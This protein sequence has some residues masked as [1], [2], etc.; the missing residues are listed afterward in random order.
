MRRRAT[1]FIAL[2]L[3]A[4]SLSGCAHEQTAQGPYR[5]AYLAD[6]GDPRL[7][8]GRP[9]SDDVVL[10]LNCQPGQD[11]IRVSALGLAG[12]EIVLTSGKTE[13]RFPAQALEDDMSGSRLLEG[14]GRTTAPALANFRKSGDLTLMAP[15]GRHSLA[16]ASADRSKVRNFFKA[17]RA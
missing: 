1:A 13:S 11:Q 8:Y 7:A 4:A 2:S 6:D 9:N 12:Q 14:R 15:S 3:L 16:A 17:C 10:M 5:W